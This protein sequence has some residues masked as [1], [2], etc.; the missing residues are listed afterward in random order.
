MSGVKMISSKQALVFI[1]AN[2]YLELYRVKK[3]KKQLTWLAENAD[4]LFVTRQV[5]NEVNKNK[6][7]VIAKFLTEEMSKIPKVDDKTLTVP[8][9]LFGL[10]ENKN[11]EIKSM[12]EELK[13][14]IKKINGCV[15]NLALEIMKTVG[16]SSDEVSAT[17]QPLF[18]NAVAHEE[19]E[20]RKA[21]ERKELGRPPG[22]A[23]EPLGDQ[24]SWENTFA[25]KN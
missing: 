21:R 15:T 4:H 20:L 3:G 5:V 10:D 12:M 2:R 25:G 18:A 6:V 1:D 13:T 19:P 23:G 11:K 16:E 9:H 17:L 14:Q 7:K 22:K 24:L 8:D